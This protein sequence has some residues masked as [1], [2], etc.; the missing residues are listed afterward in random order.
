M[1]INEIIKEFN[2]L[3]DD[4]VIRDWLKEKLSS[5]GFGIIEQNLLAVWDELNAD[6]ASVNKYLKSVLADPKLNGLF[7]EQAIDDDVV[8][9]FIDEFV[10]EVEDVPN[11]FCVFI[12][13]YF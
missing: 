12:F 9:E 3:G 11:D 10:D 8:D 13:C 7:T 4:V 2:A 1:T 6:P 5:N